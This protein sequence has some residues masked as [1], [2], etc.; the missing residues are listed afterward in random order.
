MCQIQVQ[1]IYYQDMRGIFYLYIQV[2]INYW[3]NLHAC[4]WLL[5]I[6]PVTFILE[7]HILIYYYFLPFPLV[8]SISSFII[9]NCSFI[10]ISILLSIT[11]AISAPGTACTSGHKLVITGDCRR[12]K[13]SP[14]NGNTSQSEKIQD[15]ENKLCIA[16]NYLFTRE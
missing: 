5:Q 15:V 6:I 1:G 2:Y 14:S 16:E 4:Y 7:K 3:R 13:H 11:G 10:A 8:A 9:S 12:I